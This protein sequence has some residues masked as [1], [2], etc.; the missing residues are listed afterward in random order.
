M[1]EAFDNLFLSNETWLGNW[2][3]CPTCASWKAV[4]KS[5]IHCAFTG[6]LWFLT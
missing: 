2:M 6:L 4:I 5:N 3:E 1:E